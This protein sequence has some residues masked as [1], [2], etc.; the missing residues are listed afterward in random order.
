MY[1][2]GRDWGLGMGAPQHEPGRGSQ[3]PPMWIRGLEG[4]HSG[5]RVGDRL[6][7]RALGNWGPAL[8][9]LRGS[10]THPCPC[11]PVFTPEHRGGSRLPPGWP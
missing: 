4:P 8:Y 3:L 5:L 9:P 7:G 2:V 6:P 10:C 1:P 11:P